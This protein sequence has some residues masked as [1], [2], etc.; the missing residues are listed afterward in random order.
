[1]PSLEEQIR[2]ML[3]D[4]VIYLGWLQKWQVRSNFIW[5]RTF[6]DKVV[7]R[8]LFDRRP[9]LGQMADKVAV[10]SYVEARLGSR[11]LPQLYYL[12]SDPETIPFDELPNR[13]VVKP[14]HGSGWVHLVEDKSTLDRTAL[15]DQCKAWLNESYYDQYRVWVYKNIKPLIMIEEFI[16]DGSRPAPNDYKLF[17]FDGVVELIQ[18]DSER[19]TGHRRRL[20]SIAWEK[21]DVLFNYEDIIGDLP[22]PQHLGEMIAA[23]EVLG[24]GIDFVR[25]DFYDTPERLYFGELTTTPEGGTASFHPREFDLYLGGRWK[26]P[27]KRL[28][29]SRVSG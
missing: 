26:L 3:P 17:V 15:I 29:L 9:V 19:F 18:V 23:A 24:K 4:W 10:R 6:N 20:Y 11:L 13:F 12:T 5:P 14:T 27:R 8:I 25:A 2:K 28:F 16:D 7:H 22:R 21:L 1:M